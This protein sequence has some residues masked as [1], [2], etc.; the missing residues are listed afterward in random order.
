MQAAGGYAE[1]TF[2]LPNSFNIV[3][4]FPGQAPANPKRQGPYHK[5][6]AIP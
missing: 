4:G 2:K 3:Q 5:Q 6:R 1:R